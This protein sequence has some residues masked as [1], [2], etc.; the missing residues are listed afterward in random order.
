MVFCLYVL[1]LLGACCWNFLVMK[2]DKGLIY[3][4]TDYYYI[5]YCFNVLKWRC[6][7]DHAF[8]TPKLGMKKKERERK[9]TF[10]RDS[11]KPKSREHKGQRI[12][13]PYI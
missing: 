1:A 3:S 5:F 13:L 10:L 4:F 2:V 6:K 8:L 11:K 9:K 7:A 12:A